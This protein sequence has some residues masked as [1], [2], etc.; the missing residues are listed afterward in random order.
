MRV[1]MYLLLIIALFMIPIQSTHA[2]E[3][4]DSPTP[5]PIDW[6]EIKVLDLKTAWRI[7]LADSPSL[8]AAQA[9]VFQAEARVRQAQSAY[10]P[11][12]EALASTAHTR[13]SD[14]AAQARL[15]IGGEN[16]DTYHHLGLSAGWLL[17]NGFERKF[18]HF[19]ARYGEQESRQS[20]RDARRLLADSV[21]AIYYTA[22]LALE[23]MAIV[24]ADEKFNRRQA[25][26]AA[27]RLRL[28][29][30]ALSDALN[31][32][33]QVNTAK[34]RM[35]QAQQNFKAAMIGL[36]ALLGVDT[37]TF[38]AQME[39]AQLPR[40]TE[41]T[42]APPRLAPLIDHALAH[43]PDVLAADYALRRT[44]A[45][46][47]AAQAKFYPTLNLF[48]A[49]D[50]DRTTD[51]GFED[52]DFGD[53][54]G[55]NLSYNLFKGGGDKAR[56]LEARHKQKEAEQNF[57]QAKITVTSEVKNALS[58][59]ESVQQQV[60]LQRT[61]LT[62]A[63]Q[64]RDLVDKEFAAGEASLVRLNEAQRELTTAQA[65]L[66]L[67]LVSLHQAWHNLKV[68]TAQILAELEAL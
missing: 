29:T 8:A 10:W 19:A 48:A 53:S 22:Q 18:N 33:I 16:P 15:A 50:G 37:V 49:V 6:S 2:T 34:T 46:I 64:N 58:Q 45:G 42:L 4:A 31:F 55:L 26:E 67:A 62:L 5:K 41:K 44:Q 20:F 38:P 1:P 23:D 11:T 27:A 3:R 17:F 9:R 40:E 14:N 65:R 35:I 25:E 43:R 54:V 24:T 51:L 61:N 68:S 36:A 30:G 52:D 7:A 63:R 39:L 66:A 60:R 21:A 13:L 59:L 56:L 12:L 28:G 47:G 57:L 32:Q